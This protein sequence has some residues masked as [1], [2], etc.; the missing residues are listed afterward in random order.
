MHE[1]GDD[2]STGS[3]RRVGGVLGHKGISKRKT[4]PRDKTIPAGWLAGGW[5]ASSCFPTTSSVPKLARE[6]NAAHC[7][8]ARLKRDSD[9]GYG[10]ARP[11]C[12]KASAGGEREIVR[13]LWRKEEG[14]VG[15]RIRGTKS[16]RHQVRPRRTNSHHSQPTNSVKPSSA[17]RTNIQCRAPRG[18]TR[19]TWSRRRGRRGK[20]K[21][22]NKC[23]NRKRRV[24]C[25]VVVSMTL[26]RRHV[27][28]REMLRGGVECV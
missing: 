19:R 9:R 6:S 21:S 22:E 8:T 20:V 1:H 3:W 2:G 7:P 12:E 28:T 17:A 4:S 10:L 11:G 18:H 27:L 25:T 16:F 13:I 15:V 24:G 23:R 14:S 5:R 26:I